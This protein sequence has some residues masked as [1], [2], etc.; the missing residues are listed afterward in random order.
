MEPW[1]PTS[2]QLDL[3]IALGLSAAYLIATF[4]WIY[5]DGFAEHDCY[6]MGAG[7]VQA[8]WQGTGLLEPMLYFPVS[9]PLY[10]LLF[11]NWPGPV[12]E[13]LN[14]LIPLM[15]RLSW[16]A[17]GVGVGL[18]YGII[19]RVAPPAWAGIGVV[20]AFTTPTLFEMGTYGHPSS[21]A[22]HASF[23]SLASLMSLMSL[24]SLL[25]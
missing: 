6:V 10:Y 13:N 9:Q 5:Q 17:M 19:R 4:P 16:L 20:A 22:L 25:I 24:M 1:K 15:N 12:A 11:L 8:T 7:V 23:L 14:G 21:L 2:R 18:L 3:L